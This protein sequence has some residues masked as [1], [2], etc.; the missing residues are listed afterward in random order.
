MYAHMKSY[1]SKRAKKNIR[2]TKNNKNGRH[3]DD[4][5][6]FLFSHD[7]CSF[8]LMDSHTKGR[9]A[10]DART[11]PPSHKYIYARC[12][13]LLN[14]MRIRF[15][16]RVKIGWVERNKKRDIDGREIDWRCCWGGNKGKKR[17]RKRFFILPCF[18]KKTGLV[19]GGKGYLMPLGKL[20]E[21]RN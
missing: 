15:H 21:R 6:P 20:L 4:I 12:H 1:D 8:A 3:R 19:L 13:T 7:L 18:L 17:K 2:E 16:F 9:R 5:H 14:L 10:K 11:T